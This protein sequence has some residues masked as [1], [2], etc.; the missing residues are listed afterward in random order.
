MKMKDAGS[1][2]TPWRHNDVQSVTVDMLRFVYVHS[3]NERNE[4]NK[5]N[6]RNTR[7]NTFFIFALWP[8]GRLRQLRKKYAGGGLL[9]YS[10]SE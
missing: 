4:R 1:F 7:I 10:P 5:H 3:T 9:L 8:L 2:K 6:V